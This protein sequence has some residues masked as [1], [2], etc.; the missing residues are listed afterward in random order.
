MRIGEAGLLPV[1]YGIAWRCEDR[2]QSVC[3]P[4]PINWI[5]RW[6]RQVW[7]FLRFPE[8]SAWEE[9]WTIRI[10]DVKSEAYGRGFNEG[11]REATRRALEF[12]TKGSGDAR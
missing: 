11:Y 10:L 6:L 9:K 4:V 2:L 12:Y 3:L 5:A 1:G 8:W 7:I